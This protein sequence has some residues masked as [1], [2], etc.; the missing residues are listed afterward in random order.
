[1]QACTAA[2]TLA[3]HVGLHQGSAPTLCMPELV[4]VDLYS[5]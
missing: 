2:L 5:A 1:M 3:A 4:G